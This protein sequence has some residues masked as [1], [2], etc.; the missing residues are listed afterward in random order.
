MI[1][2]LA[3]ASHTGKTTLAQKLLE[4]YN[5][6]Y[7]SIDHLKR[8]LIRSGYTKLTPEDDDEL[9]EYLWPIVREMVRTAIEN[10]QNLI[11]ERCY[12]PFD[13]EKD[14]EREYLAHIQYYCLVMSQ[15]YIKNHF[16]NIKNMPASLK[17][18]G[19]TRDAYWKMC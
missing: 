14:F 15:E 9:T 2:L 13:W 3:G 6:P 1:V 19:R 5:Y 7:I 17:I 11:V 10:N 8:G 18:E 4:R 12:I 16:L